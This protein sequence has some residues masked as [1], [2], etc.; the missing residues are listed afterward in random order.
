VDHSRKW[1]EDDQAVNGVK[2]LRIASDQREP[3][4]ESS[5]RD[6]RVWQPDAVLLPQRDGLLYYR[7][8][9]WDFLKVGEQAHRLLQL[10]RSDS[11]SI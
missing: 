5:G 10:I 3:K 7:L 6:Q 2:I 9:K 11:A 8:V 1:V 4:V